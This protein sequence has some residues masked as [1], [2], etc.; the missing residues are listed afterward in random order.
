MLRYH[1]DIS[2]VYATMLINRC[3][4]KMTAIW[5]NLTINDA[6]QIKEECKLCSAKNIKRRYYSII[7]QY[8]QT[9]RINLKT[10]NY[11]S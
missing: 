2:L 6:N 4:K 9:S 1:S 7:L 8:K 10:Y 11:R 5:T 3:H